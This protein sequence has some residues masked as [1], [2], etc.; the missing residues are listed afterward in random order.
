MGMNLDMVRQRFD[1][2]RNTAK[3]NNYNKLNND[4]LLGDNELR[5]QMDEFQGHYS[6]HSELLHTSHHVATRER[7]SK[8][9]VP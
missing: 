5:A 8:L 2:F 6:E 7:Y 4:H 9:H 3:N 1:E